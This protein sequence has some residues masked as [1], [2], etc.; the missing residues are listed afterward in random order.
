MAIINSCCFWKSLKKGSIA[1]AIYSL[2]SLKDLKCKMCRL[3][4]KISKKKT[5]SSQT[6]YQKKLFNISSC[7]FSLLRSYI[8]SYQQLQ[9]RFICTM[10]G[11][12]SWESTKGPQIKAFLARLHVSFECIRSFIR[13]ILMEN[14][15]FKFSKNFHS[16]CDHQHA[17]ARLFN[18]WNYRI[19]PRRLRFEKR[20]T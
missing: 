1:S 14:S 16:Q 5:C 15:T 2:V 17:I 11:P 19:R 8:L 12:S 18:C 13:G 3:I 7:E 10:S 20:S 6:K 9:S 4:N